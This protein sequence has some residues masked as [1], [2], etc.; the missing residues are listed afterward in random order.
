MPVALLAQQVINGK[1]VDAETEKPV[2]YASVGIIGTPEGTSSNIEGEFSLF[3]FG[4]GSLKISCIGYQSKIVSFREASDVI[5]LKAI[6]TQ[7]NAVVVLNKSVNPKKVVRKA[8]ANI[9]SN[10]ARQTFLQKF[11]YRH[12]CKDDS[13]Y[14][15]LIEASVE[16]IKTNGY[17]SFRNNGGHNEEMRVTQLRRSLDNTALAQGHEPI[18]I[19][20][21]LEADFAAYQRHDKSAYVTLHMGVSNLR[22]DFENYDFEFKGV[23]L[24]DDQEV[25]HIR[26]VHKKDSALT[27]A[28]SYINRP[29]AEGSLFIGT[30]NFAILKTEDVKRDGVNELRTTAY[31][32]KYGDA[33]YPY[34]FIREG[35]N[36]LT[37]RSTHFFH[38]ELMSVD[39]QKNSFEKFKG[40]EPSAEQL[41]LVPYDSAYWSN[42]TVLKTTPLENQIIADLGGG[43]S[44]DK[45][46]HLYKQYQFNTQNGGD[47][48]EQKF[49][50]LK[51]FSRGRKAL[52]IFFWSSNFKN[53]LVD[54]ELAKR[55]NK[56]F[57]N[58]FTFVFVSLDDD[59]AAWK[60][61]V[62]KFNLFSDGII[63]YRIGSHS[64]L[65]KE[66][67][68]KE[69]PAF[70]M[71]DKTG[72]ILFNVKKPSDSSL[73]ADLK[74]F[75]EK[76]Q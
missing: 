28:G 73:A 9:S 62:S 57:R 61:S 64:K 59:D 10:Y 53:Y 18:S 71:I 35:E 33:Y 67:R 52:Y 7:L 12:Y 34:H 45:Q 36:S 66:Y 70:L 23:T 17:S 11:F 20:N 6:T 27:T 55:L 30:D 4:S 13:V 1:I 58:K 44:L 22:A 69:L 51:Q 39:I 15:R 74:V 63:N 72:E 41:L 42:H 21:I 68:V 8:F 16:V 19:K 31:Y 25:Y 3:V 24:F 48:G 40:S 46:F 56:E 14:G 65:L 54:V 37:D 5:R 75:A 47:Q 43:T 32:R 76:S 49:N 50:W 2:P 26:Y 38:I 60:Q 29:E